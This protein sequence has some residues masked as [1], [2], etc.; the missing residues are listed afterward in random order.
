M[1]MQKLNTKKNLWENT[2]KR[3]KIKLLRTCIFLVATYGC[4]SLTITQT[5]NKK[6]G[7]FE[8]KCYRM[9]LRILW[10]IKIMQIS[11][12]NLNLTTYH[13]KR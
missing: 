3:I 1:V 4:E 9:V 8:T 12:K 10:T 2:R 6:I 11:Y 5:I 7:W 13:T